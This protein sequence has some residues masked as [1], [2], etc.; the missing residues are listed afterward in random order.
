M[1]SMQWLALVV[2]AVVVIHVTRVNGQARAKK[3][4][5]AAQQ[6]V[7]TKIEED[8]AG[9]GTTEEKAWSRA[10]ENAVTRAKEMLQ[11]HFGGSGW[12]SLVEQI[13]AAELEREKVI[14]R[15]DKA[16]RAEKAGDWEVKAVYRVDLNDP[17]LRKLAQEARQQTVVERHELLARVLGGILAVVLVTAAYLRLEEMTRGYATRLLRLAAVVLLALVGAGLYLTR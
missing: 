11:E 5:A 1:R 3:A 14:F 15:R 2:A 8:V 4:K 16:E 7:A 13:T 6:Q 10:R 9:F 12:Q 17:Y